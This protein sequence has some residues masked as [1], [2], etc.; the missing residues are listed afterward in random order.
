[1]ECIS[2][3]G[4]ILKSTEV[5]KYKVLR[6]YKNSCRRSVLRKNLTREEAK[7]VVNSYPD[8]N[9]SMVIFTKQ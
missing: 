6:V 7:R 5:E 1:M 2:S 8:R 3:V 4:P 9:L